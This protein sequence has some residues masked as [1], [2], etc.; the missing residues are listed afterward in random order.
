MRTLKPDDLKKILADLKLPAYEA[1]VPV[2][3]YDSKSHSRRAEYVDFPTPLELVEDP[4]YEDTAPRSLFN[5]IKRNLH[6]EEVAFERLSK[7]KTYEET[8]M[9]SRSLAREATTQGSQRLARR[10]GTSARRSETIAQTIAE[11][12]EDAVVYR[13]MSASHSA[14]AA[15]S[16]TV[17]DEGGDEDLFA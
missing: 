5:F 6:I 15:Y 2:D 3:A 13:G 16:Q 12:G 8:A 17:G 14:A 7:A 10:F 1:T 4:E 11:G 9:I